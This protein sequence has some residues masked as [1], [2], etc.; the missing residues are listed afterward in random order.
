MRL[1]DKVALVSGAENEGVE[2]VTAILFAGNVPG[3]RD[4][5]QKSEVI[6]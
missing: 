2:Q 3:R 6:S 1:Q 4:G 5:R